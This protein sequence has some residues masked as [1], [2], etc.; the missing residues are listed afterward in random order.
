MMFANI[1]SS[2]NGGI[3]QRSHP[4]SKKWYSGEFQT[5]KN[6]MTNKQ[7]EKENILWKR[8]LGNSIFGGTIGLALAHWLLTELCLV[9]LAGP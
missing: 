5:W 2:S 9:D 3:L 4:I 7:M 6:L 8:N 1:L